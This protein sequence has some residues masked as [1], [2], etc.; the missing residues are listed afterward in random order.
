MCKVFYGDRVPKPSNEAQ[1][2]E[3]LYFNKD[4]E[5]IANAKCGKK[6]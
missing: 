1:G 5:K 3:S 6:L 2:C 4:F